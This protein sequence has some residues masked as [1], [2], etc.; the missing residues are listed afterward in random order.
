[1]NCPVPNNYGVEFA[2]GVVQGR[3]YK[4]FLEEAY[5]GSPFA[6]STASSTPTPSATPTASSTS[7]ACSTSTA[8]STSA[9][10][11]TPPST[12][13]SS[14][15]SP[16]STYSWLISIS[17]S[18][19][20]TKSSPKQITRSPPADFSQGVLGMEPPSFATLGCRDLY[21]PPAPHHHHHHHY[22][23]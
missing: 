5:Y 6:I 4:L 16:T 14:M 1:M 18:Y 8:S 21:C 20:P 9:A 19:P 11:S 23:K 15:S 3:G 10:S 2:C 7:T 17:K 13:P 22:C 12:L